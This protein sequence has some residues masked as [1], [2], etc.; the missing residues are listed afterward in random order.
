MVVD[1]L[2]HRLHNSHV[3]AQGYADYVVLLQK[4]KFDSTLC[5]RMHGALNCIENWCG[6]IGLSVNADKTTMVL[7]TNN[8]KTGGFYNPRLLGTELKIRSAFTLCVSYFQD[9]PS[10]QA[11]YPIS[12]P[13]ISPDPSSSNA[14]QFSQ[15]QDRVVMLWERLEGY[16]RRWCPSYTL[17]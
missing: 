15:F 14:I 12:L 16:H 6:E 17:P 7:P 1:S 5:D 13:D 4:G 8:R 9:V 10:N 11:S 3:Q 2:L